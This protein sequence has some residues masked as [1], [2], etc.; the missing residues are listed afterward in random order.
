ME[1]R[2]GASVV[3]LGGP[4]P[5]S[6]WPLWEATELLRRAQQLR[7]ELQ[8]EAQNCPELLGEA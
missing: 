6:A 8:A 2:A 4:W 5:G 1:G 3:G 7:Q